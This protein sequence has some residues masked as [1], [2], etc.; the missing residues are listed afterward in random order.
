MLLHLLP[1]DLGARADRPT[2]GRPRKIPETEDLVLEVTIIAEE[3]LS[4][5]N[6]TNSAAQGTVP[7]T[8]VASGMSLA[9]ADGANP[10]VVWDTL[11][12]EVEGTAAQAAV[13][14][15]TLRPSLPR[16]CKKTLK[17]EKKT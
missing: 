10:L 12:V 6:V 8:A 2:R 9:T 13:E 14:Q 11:S 16:A 7:L 15:S 3:T 1:V 17:K 5:A 4:E